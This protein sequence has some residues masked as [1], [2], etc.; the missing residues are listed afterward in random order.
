MMKML[1][2]AMTVPP[3]FTSP[4]RSRSPGTSRTCPERM[5]FATDIISFS[6]FSLSASSLVRTFE[7]TESTTKF[8][9]DLIKSF[10][11]S[12]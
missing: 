7:L 5:I 4:I 3:G 8:F 11:S 1:P 6:F 10:S 12:S 2:P 9:F